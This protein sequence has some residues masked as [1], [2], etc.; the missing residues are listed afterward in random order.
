MKRIRVTAGQGPLGSASAT[1]PQPPET[2]RWGGG[3]RGPNLLLTAMNQLARTKQTKAAMPLMKYGP[4]P[5]S[6]GRPR[7]YSWWDEAPRLLHLALLNQV[8]EPH[9]PVHHHHPLFFP[10]KYLLGKTLVI[11]PSVATNLAKTPA[12]TGREDEAVDQSGCNRSRGRKWWNVLRRW[13]ESSNHLR[14]VVL[15]SLSFISPTGWCCSAGGK[16]KLKKKQLDA[17][18]QSQNDR[19]KRH[20][21]LTARRPSSS[22]RPVPW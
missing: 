5:G 22:A 13:F 7:R 12:L 19:T 10:C 14:S 18:Q 16:R 2:C 3:D 15:F 21:A 9:H 17:K 1:R 20:A 11:P 6:L 8:P 4:L